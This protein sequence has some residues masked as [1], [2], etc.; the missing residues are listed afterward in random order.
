MTVTLRPNTEL[1]MVTWLGLTL[2]PSLVA[3][4]LPA[5]VTRWADAGFCQVTALGGSSDLYVPQH[6]PVV[7][8]DFWAVKP[9]SDQPPWGKAAN[10]VEIV[11]AATYD[12][13]LMGRTLTLPGDY[14]DAK[15]QTAYFLSEPVRVPNDVAS[16]AHYNVNA[17]L[18]WR[19]T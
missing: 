15:F 14:P 10:L 19:P 2:D 9:N 5:D 17:A 16:Y 1:V 6:N 7:S 3:T 13:A 11:R 18:H 4:T 12:T 8:L